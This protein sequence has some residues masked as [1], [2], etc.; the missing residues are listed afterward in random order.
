MAKIRDIYRFIDEI[1]PF[2]TQMD[3]DNSGLLVG[4]INKSVKRVILSLDITNEVVLEAKNKGAK[5]IIS[6][7]PVIFNPLKKIS[8]DSP[9]ELIIK[10]DI[11]ALCAHTNLDM[12]SD[13]GVNASLAK[14]LGLKSLEPLSFYN[15]CACSFKGKLE[16]KMSSTEFADYVNQKL[17]CKHLR[18]VDS[19]KTISTVGICSGGAGEYIFDAIDN[20]LDAF[21]SGEFKHHEMLAAKHNNITAIEAGHFNTEVIYIDQLIKVLQ[22][23]FLDTEFLKSQ[24]EKDI[25]SYI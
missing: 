19:K 21:I 4:D 11:A 5:L 25:I 14:I 6:H 1:A 22:G 9:V 17:N 23:E 12:A 7:H 13:I 8:V 24:D 10:H 20:N 3:F 18:F 15:G 16:N 2:N